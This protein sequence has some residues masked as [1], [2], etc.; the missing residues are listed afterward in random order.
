MRPAATAW[1]EDLAKVGDVGHA[2]QEDGPNTILGLP[3]P[4]IGAQ[5]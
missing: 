1:E 3:V 4:S 5:G 2:T